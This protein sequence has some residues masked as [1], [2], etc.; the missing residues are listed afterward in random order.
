MRSI[1]IYMQNDLETK[2]ISENEQIKQKPPFRKN[3]KFKT[4]YQFNKNEIYT[5]ISPCVLFMSDF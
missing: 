3:V 5:Y 2:L 4:L 1:P